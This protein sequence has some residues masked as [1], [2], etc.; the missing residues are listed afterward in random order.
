M[1]KRKHTATRKIFVFILM[2]E[3]I[4]LISI[5]FMKYQ[6][7]SFSVRYNDTVSNTYITKNY[8][9]Q[10][11]E[12]A[13]EHETLLLNYVRSNSDNIIEYIDEAQAVA[14]EIR[15]L[16]QGLADIT[17]KTDRETLYHS[18]NDSLVNY[19]EN[20]DILIFLC[21]QDAKYSAEFYLET[22]MLP[23]LTT[24]NNAV[25]EMDTLSDLELE[26]ARA[27][28]NRSITYSRVVSVISIVVMIIG[29][30][31]SL[32]YAVK[33]LKGLESVKN[34]LEDD[35]ESKNN[36][37]FAIQNKI[38]IGIAD[39]I[40]NRSGETGQHVKRTSNYVALIVNKAKEK[41]MWK[42]VIDDNYISNIIKAAP[43]HDIGKIVVSDSIL[44]KPGR[45]TDDEFEEMKRH[46]KEGGRIVKELI[47]GI[48]D[49]DYIEMSINIATYHHEKWNGKGYPYG[50]AGEDIPLCAR[51]MAVADV[52][53][54]LVSERCYKK[55]MSYDDAFA[56]IE[57]DAGSHFDPD[58]AAIFLELRPEIESKNNNGIQ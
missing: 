28:L 42:D 22:N 53:D 7:D 27:G 55:A 6:Y 38:I 16:L 41:G 48:E 8:T 19:I 44:N 54:A 30:T 58:V 15:S 4:G 11:K 26:N 14:L 32:R 29:I 25:K 36:R 21:N 40:E 50:I 39:L 35:V 9:A 5:L 45:F 51:I 17:I 52:F 3:L 56:I 13:Y 46:A 31:I 10:I 2:S 20:S 43:L 12:K 57:K 47:A 18:V 33:N 49:E 1:N 23:L 24:M 34:N 37:I